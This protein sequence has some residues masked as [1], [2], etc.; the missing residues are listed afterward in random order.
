[1]KCI[2]TSP[3]QKDWFCKEH[4]LKKKRTYLQGQKENGLCPKITGQQNWQS[5]E[6]EQESLQE[7]SQN[8]KG[9]AIW[10][11]TYTEIIELQWH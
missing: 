11:R 8:S 9:N 7:K 1:M 4:K 10:N 2:Y 5:T 3:T 6:P